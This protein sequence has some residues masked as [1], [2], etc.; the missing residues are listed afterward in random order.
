MGSVLTLDINTINN[1]YV[2]KVSAPRILPK[3]LPTGNPSIEFTADHKPGSYLKV[4][5][6]TRSLKS[7]S[8]VKVAGSNERK[9]E[10]NGKELVR[11]G[12]AK[13]DN[14]ISNTVTLP[15][16]KSLTTTLSWER[17]DMTKNQGAMTF[18]VNA[19][20]ENKRIGAYSFSRKGQISATNG[21]LNGAWKGQT[22]AA[23]VAWMSPVD[24]DV[25]FDLNSNT[26]SYVFNISKTAAGK[27]MSISYNNGRFSIDF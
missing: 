6:N 26:N 16:G 17:D 11:A 3:I 15:N 21:K 7:F 20:G 5:S 8:V 10:L 27:K 22:A 4:T 19:N 14:E 1:P 9:I 23:K 24:T 12:F 18:D 2:F 13:G 25:S